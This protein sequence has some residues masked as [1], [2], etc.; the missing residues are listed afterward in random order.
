MHEYQKDKD[1]DKNNNYFL[2]ILLCVY[3]A[4]VY[5]VYFLYSILTKVC[6]AVLL[7]AGVGVGGLCVSI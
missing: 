1:K 6:K 4:I 7:E 5:V 3:D 2:D